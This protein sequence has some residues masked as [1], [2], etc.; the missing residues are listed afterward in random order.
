[1]IARREDK[2]A[3]PG[4]SLRDA[5]LAADREARP[6]AFR[7]NV[8][9]RLLSAVELGKALFHWGLLMKAGGALDPLEGR[10]TEW[11]V[12][13]VFFS[14]A[15]PVAAVGLWIGAGWGV[16]IWLLAALGDILFTAFSA[17]PTPG[18]WV[19][20]GLTVAAMAGFVFLSAKAR[21][22]EA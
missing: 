2:A 19:V 3:L 11:L 9:L 6:W 7:L 10:S 18:R 17:A 22:E 4:I 16:V 21:R 14:V 8:F 5:S 15:D 20:V 12:S 1:M 13:S